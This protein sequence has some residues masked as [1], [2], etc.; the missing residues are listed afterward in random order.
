[1]NNQDKIRDWAFVFALLFLGT[2]IF[3]HVFTRGD[4]DTIINYTATFEPVTNS[5]VTA[6][7]LADI[8]LACIN[9]CLENA[10][11]IDESSCI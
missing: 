1:M 8:K 4:T 5:T 6:P 11:S 10:G 9:L 7:S 2:S 3:F